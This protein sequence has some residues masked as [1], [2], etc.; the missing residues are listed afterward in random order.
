MKI[1]LPTTSRGLGAFGIGKPGFKGK[2]KTVKS[3][4]SVPKKIPN[5]FQDHMVIPSSFP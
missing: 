4:K 3:V 1:T 2:R 5:E